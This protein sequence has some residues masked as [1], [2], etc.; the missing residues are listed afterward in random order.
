MDATFIYLIFSTRKRAGI[1]LPP[2]FIL[3]ARASRP[4]H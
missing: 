1:L 2:R 3:P 4:V